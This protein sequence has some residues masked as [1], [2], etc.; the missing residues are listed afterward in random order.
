MTFLSRKVDYALLILS[1]LH[2]HQ[3]AGASAH[4]IA[5]HY[6]LGRPFVANI[7]KLLCQKGFVESHRGVKGGYVLHRPPAGV[8]LA[9]LMDALDESFQLTTCSSHAPGDQRCGIEAVCPVRHPL[10]EVHERIRELLRGVSLAQLFAA[11]PGEVGTTQFGLTLV[12]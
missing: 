2:R 9:E 8:H 12:G 3:P 11:Q 7:L 1:Y 6:G 10:A 5:E 4:K